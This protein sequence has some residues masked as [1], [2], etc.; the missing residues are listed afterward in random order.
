LTNDAPEAPPYHGYH[1]IPSNAQ[2]LHEHSPNSSIRGVHD[3][4][5]L[6]LELLHALFLH[7]F[8]GRADGFGERQPA[9]VQAVVIRD[10][11]QPDA[12]RGAQHGEC[13]GRPRRGRAFDE[14]ALAV[15]LA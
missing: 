2:K 10:D 7:D 4:Q 8:E 5:I 12:T 9:F 11:V 6:F 13:S 14:V 15:H 1:T 3:D